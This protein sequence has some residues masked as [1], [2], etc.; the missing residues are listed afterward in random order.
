MIYDETLYKGTFKASDLKMIQRLQ[1]AYSKLGEEAIA[2]EGSIYTIKSSDL[3][4]AYINLFGKD[5]YEPTSFNI[6][7]VNFVYSP[8]KNEYIAIVTN[9]INENIK[10]DLFD[11]TEDDNYI[12]MKAYVY[13]V[14]DGKAFNIQSNKEVGDTTNLANLKTKL[15][16]ATFKFTKDKYFYSITNE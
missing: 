15:S 5:D 13:K 6:M 9:P 12:T 11:I 3:K 8:N 2:T 14:I 10:Y 7:D 1:M 16:I 4:S